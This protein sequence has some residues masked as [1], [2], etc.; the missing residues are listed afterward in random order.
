[1]QLIPKFLGK[2]YAACS[3]DGYRV[4]HYAIIIWEIPFDKWYGATLLG[5][6]LRP[7]GWAHLDEFQVPGA[8]NSAPKCNGIL[9]GDADQCCRSGNRFL[10]P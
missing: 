3:V 4:P 2:D 10:P 9:L 1:M 8:T 5:G 6:M 7:E